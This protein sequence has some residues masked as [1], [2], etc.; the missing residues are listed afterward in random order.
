LPEWEPLKNIPAFS[1]SRSLQIDHDRPQPI[2]FENLRRREFLLEGK[3]KGE[4]EDGWLAVMSG[5]ILNLD[6]QGNVNKVQI[7]RAHRIQI[8]VPG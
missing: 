6:G 3:M 8:N 7:I 1:L 4:R 5:I 2:F